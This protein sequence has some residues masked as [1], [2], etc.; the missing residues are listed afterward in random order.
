MDGDR[1]NPT[2]EKMTSLSAARG[3]T[4]SAAY[5]AAYAFSLFQ[6]KVNMGEKTA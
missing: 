1:A 5:L 4:F 2:H 3:D 6:E